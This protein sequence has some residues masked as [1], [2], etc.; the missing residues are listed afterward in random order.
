P[1]RPAAGALPHEVGDAILV[2]IAA[3]N[4]VPAGEDRQL[5]RPSQ[6]VVVHQPAS[7]DATPVFPNHVDAAVVVE[8]AAGDQVPT[9]VPG[10][11]RT[12]A[13]IDR[14]RHTRAPSE[15]AHH[16]IVS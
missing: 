15:R 4:D 14:A 8:I 6:L 2:E 5:Q 12:K 10:P 1:A 13:D 16:T 9:K 3:G 7:K 11:P